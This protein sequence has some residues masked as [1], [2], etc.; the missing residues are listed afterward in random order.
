MSSSVERQDDS[1]KQYLIEEFLEDYQQGQMTR[2]D[3]LKRLVGLTAS[4][5]LSSALLAACAPA[6]QPTAATA[7]APTNIPPSA[8]PPTAQT[9]PTLASTTAPTSVAATATLASVDPTLTTAAT[10][11]VTAGNSSVNVSPD[12][13]AIQAGTVEFPSQGA[14]VMGYLARPS[15][16][17]TYPAVLI[18]H[19]NRGL[20]DHIKDVAR[21]Y[22]KAGYVALAVDLLSRQGGTDKVSEAQVPGVLGNTPPAQMVGD[23]AAGLE[24]LKQQPYVA[25]GQYGMTGFCFGGGITW[26]GATQIPELRAAVPYYGSNPPLEDVPKINAAVLGIYGGNDTRINS[27]IPAIEAAMKQ[28]NKIFEKIIYPGANHAF[29]NDTGS[30][31]NAEAARDAWSKTLAWFDKYLK[32]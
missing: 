1:L 18:A 8:I 11:T 26:R 3:A 28:N 20:T 23:F 29:H 10:A 30:N 31:Y 4:V 25:Q 9:A 32:G 6:A 24:Y 22:A 19:E 5:A 14:T 12:D 27:G 2:R 15:A 21:R 7:P 16:N 13:P 17:G